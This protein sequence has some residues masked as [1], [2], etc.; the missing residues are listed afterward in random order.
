MIIYIDTQSWSIIKQDNEIPVVTGNNYVD[1][2]TLAFNND[3]ETLKFYP[4]LNILKPNNRKVGPLNFDTATPAYPIT[5]TDDED[6]EWFLYEFTL[7]NNSGVLDVIGKFNVTITINFYNSDNNTI[8]GQRN[9]NTMLNVFNA[10]TNE[11]NDILILGNNPDD[12][13]ASLYSLLQQ[14]LT[15]NAS[16][17]SSKADRNNSLQSI[18]AG[19]IDVTKLNLPGAELAGGNHYTTLYADY[20]DSG[21]NSI[22]IGV[23][24]ADHGIEI[25]YGYNNGNPV[26]YISLTSDG[27]TSL[28]LNGITEII[29]F[30]P[31]SNGSEYK[32][33]YKGFV[34]KNENGDTLSWVNGTLDLDGNKITGLAAPTGDTEAT[35]KKYVDDLIDALQS[36]KVDKTAIY[37]GLDKVVEGFVLDARQGKALKDALDT[38]YSYVGFATEDD[39]DTTINKLREVFA[40]LTGALDN[41]TIIDLLNEK[42]NVID[43]SNKLDADFVDDTN[44]TNKFT[45]ESEKTTWN[46]KQ[47]NLSG[48]TS[49]DITSNTVSVN[50]SYVEGFFATSQ[51]IDSM[52]EEVFG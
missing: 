14:L 52:L 20:P 19:T 35:N 6:N 36:G 21:V 33:D 2:I 43:S 42:Q 7:S 4:T 30:Y 29:T 17:S 34:F 23:D 50:D 3:P 22:A 40:F 49:I 10:V 45:T 24:S 8:T 12:V 51:E 1:K 37:N 38:L 11:D 25:R 13:V 26:D 47:D 32:F 48:S 39:V 9:M 5:T 31:D 15:S 46:A 16:L 18:I 27:D 28:S 41:Q 44:S